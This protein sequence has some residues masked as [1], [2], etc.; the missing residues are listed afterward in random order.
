MIADSLVES[1]KVFE[2]GVKVFN[3]GFKKVYAPSTEAWIGVGML[4]VG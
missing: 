1:L 3:E 4:F 2:K